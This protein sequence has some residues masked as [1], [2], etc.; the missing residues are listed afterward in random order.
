MIKKENLNNFKYLIYKIHF[1]R[2]K[3]YIEEFSYT[4]DDQCPATY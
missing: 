3:L 1:V 2:P 4:S